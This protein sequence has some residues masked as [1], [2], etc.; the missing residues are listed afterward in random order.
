VTE[1]IV[2]VPT[3]TPRWFERRRRRGRRQRS[4]TPQ[5]VRSFMLS[6]RIYEGWSII[7]HPSTA[8]ALHGGRRR[9]CSK[10]WVLIVTVI[11]QFGIVIDVD[12][13][14]GIPPKSAA[15]ATGSERWDMRR[16]GSRYGIIRQTAVRGGVWW[17]WRYSGASCCCCCRRRFRWS[18]R[19]R[20]RRRGWRRRW[21]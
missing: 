1:I 21:K 12:V 17:R 13:A 7:H 6:I 11:I 20:R 2:D 9:R 16:G 15:T 5:R 8:A 4:G 14:I 3:G 10:G 19:C 18:H